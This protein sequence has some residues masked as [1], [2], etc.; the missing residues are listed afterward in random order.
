MTFATYLVSPAE[1][2]HAIK[3]HAPSKMSTTP[4][5]IP[6]CGSWFLPNDPQKRTGRQVF[7]EGHVP[8][9]RFFDLDKVADISSPYPHMLPAA[10]VFQQAMEDLG[11]EKQDVLVVYDTKELGIF[12]APRVAWTLKAFGHAS[13]HLLNNY[14]LYVEQGYSVEEGEEEAVGK[15]KYPLPQLAKDKVV[16]FEE[17]KAIAKDYNKEGKEDIDILDARSEGRWKGTDPEPRPGLE[18][19]HIPGSTN[20]PVPELLDPTTK[21]YLSATELRKVFE[22]K[23]VDPRKHIISSCGTG[24]TAAVIDTALIE[25]G[26]GDGVRRVYDGSWTEWAQRIQ[27]SDNLILKSS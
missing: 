1:L 5:T 27:P 19:G 20:V 13:V 11:V 16:A 8:G 2:D 18:S 21:A 22:S 26:Y 14:K 4:K 7:R 10:K 23:G 17:M 24:V 6:I 9:A 3:S 12:S 15:T 25:A